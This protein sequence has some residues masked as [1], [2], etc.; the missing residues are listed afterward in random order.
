MHWRTSGSSKEPVDILICGLGSFEVREHTVN[1]ATEPKLK[2]GP[3]RRL[4][5]RT[6]R[7]YCLRRMEA[8]KIPLAVPMLES[9]RVRVLVVTIACKFLERSR[10]VTSTVYEVKGGQWRNHIKAIG[11]QTFWAG[12]SDPRHEPTRRTAVRSQI[13]YWGIIEVAVDAERV[14]FPDRVQ[15]AAVALRPYMHTPRLTHGTLRVISVDLHR[16]GEMMAIWF[17]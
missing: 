16:E 11:N 7:Q 6:E 12:N 8:T 9:V 10:S 2:A 15:L 1:T 4:G 14:H 3:E 13:H 5:V 17:P